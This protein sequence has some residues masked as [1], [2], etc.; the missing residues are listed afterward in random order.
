VIGAPVQQNSA[1]SP[2]AAM[3]AALEA[4]LTERRAQECQASLHEFV[5][6]F[7]HVVEPGAAFEDN[8]HIG[9]MCRH[10][11][12]V[13]AGTIKNLL[14]NVPPGTSKS[15]VVS[16]MFPAWVWANDKAKRFFG[17]SYSEPLSIR[18]TL[19]CRDIITS[20]RYRAMYP[21]VQ[22]K[23]A[24][25]QKTQ[26]DLEDGGWRVAT[27]VGGRG[28]GMH[29]HF[30]IVDDPH[31]VKESESDVE[32]QAALDWFDGTLSS[33]GLILNAATIV[34]MQRL[35]QKD[36]TGHIMSSPG[37]KDW[38]HLVI[39]ME[40]EPMRPIPTT[41]LG[42][43]DP[44][45]KAGE[46]L[47][48]K[49]FPPRAVAQLAMT[50][51][52]Y[53]AAGQLQQRPSP[54]GGGILQVEQ[55]KLWPRDQPLPDVFFVLQSYDTAFTATTSND[56]T[57]C[58]VWGVGELPRRKRDSAIQRFAILLDGWTEHMEYPALREKVID[59]WGARYG[60]VKNDPLHPSRKA[61]VV[62]VE[63]KG[64]GISL[65]Q[66]MRAAAVPVHG[67]NPGRADKVAR[68]HM[69]APFLEAGLVYVLESKREPGK[70]ITWAR[71][72]VTQC[73]EFPNGE[74]DDLVDTLTQAIIYM[75][76][77]GLLEL[78]VA[79]PEE[80]EDVDYEERRSSRRNPY[81]Q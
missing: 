69:V 57:A 6:E 11:E 28:T 37:Y 10:L 4:E 75:R 17:A 48:P 50:L 43:R 20:D 9:E 64:S 60:G 45:K 40:Y 29:P 73:E 32:R 70:P 5:K 15:T 41:R 77:A 21:D 27:S 35:H 79:A 8:W 58:T 13:Y 78:R 52:T 38:D 81:S 66:D 16:V 1:Q 14:I 61:D 18:D 33:R 54:E 23:R 47:W 51:G 7:W 34:I 22:L 72:L 44:R 59:D 30:K 67:Y 62:L 74:H 19:L 56:P 36:L 39:P 53:R 25:N 49:M 46:L 55:I 65:M 26:Y 63:E 80:P 76:D 68:A 31:N 2:L 3:I 24:S 42:F 12:A 71:P